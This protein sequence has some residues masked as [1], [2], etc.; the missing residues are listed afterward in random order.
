MTLLRPAIGSATER[1]P[2]RQ[3]H[4][5][6][7]SARGTGRVVH[8]GVK[9]A[10]N[11]GFPLPAAPQVLQPLMVGPEGAQARPPNR[12]PFVS[13]CDVRSRS[14]LCLL[15]GNKVTQRRHS[16]W[17]A[18][19]QRVEPL[20]ALQD[21]PAT[22]PEQSWMQ[23]CLLA[24]FHETN[25]HIRSAD[26]KQ[27]SI[28]G[29]YLGLVGLVLSL[30]PGGVIEILHGTGDGAVVYMFLLIVG[31]CVSLYQAWCRVWKVHYLATL[32]HVVK[33]WPLDDFLL[34]YWLRTPKGLQRSA[35]RRLNVD[36][37]LLYFT[38]F[39]NTALLILVS[40]QVW[41]LLPTDWR[42]LALG[43]LALAYAWFLFLFYRVSTNNED[44][45][46]A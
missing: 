26:Q 11:Y 30:L 38:L 8:Q 24:L 1:L 21:P 10:N 39:L 35:W 34:P 31:C 9:P 5:A 25:E 36:N 17:S 15:S 18:M 42:T 43:A 23:A 41:Y 45:L 6:S 4:G 46:I 27:T 37:T 32:R 13:G 40:Y 12:F 22:S 28:A 16:D 33:D 29:A 20:A 14:V 2:R 3:R 44:N 7:A 19:S